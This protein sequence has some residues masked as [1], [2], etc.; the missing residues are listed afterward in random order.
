[1]QT[2]RFSKRSLQRLQGVHPQLVLI[3]SRA[4]LYSEVDFAITE[5]V[6]DIETQKRYVSEGKSQTLQSRHL[7][8][9]AIDVVAYVNGRI[10]W[11]WDLYVEI[12]RAF[13]RAAR[14]LGFDIEWGGDWTAFKD[15]VHFQRGKDGA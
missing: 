4:L 7:T 10:S 1:M 11:Q 3:A 8:G 5:G 13:K 15:G 9:D 2:Y 14:E 12:A 6:R